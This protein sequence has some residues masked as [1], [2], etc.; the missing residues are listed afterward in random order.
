MIIFKP[1]GV[2]DTYNFDKQSLKIAFNPDLDLSSWSYDNH[3]KN[4]T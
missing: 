4:K 3:I 2:C 1:I